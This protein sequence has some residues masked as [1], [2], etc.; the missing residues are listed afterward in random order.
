M[1]RGIP[2]E[3]MSEGTCRREGCERDTCEGSRYYCWEHEREEQ[4]EHAER[5]YEERRERRLFGEET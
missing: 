2:G 3:A 4:Q 1:V 5:L